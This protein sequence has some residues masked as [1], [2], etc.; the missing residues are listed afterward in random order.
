MKVHEY[1]GF[2]VFF[3]LFYYYYFASK[4]VKYIFI[5]KMGTKGATVGMEG[6]GRPIQTGKKA[7]LT[8]GDNIVREESSSTSRKERFLSVLKSL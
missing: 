6:S 7:S 1:K 2:H 5:K 4:P 3:F 8:S